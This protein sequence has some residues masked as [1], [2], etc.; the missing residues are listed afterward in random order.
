MNVHDFVT[1][2]AFLALYELMHQNVHHIYMKNQ[3]KT[4]ILWNGTLHLCLLLCQIIFFNFLSTDSQA[5]SFAVIKA[6]N[7]YYLYVITHLCSFSQMPLRA[8]T[9]S[10]TLL[11]LFSGMA[12]RK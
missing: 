10:S 12:L 11:S 7:Y 6:I 1:W 3:T 5:H 2:T 8:L 4:G 9:L